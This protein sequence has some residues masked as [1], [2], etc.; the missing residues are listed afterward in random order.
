MAKSFEEQNLLDLFFKEIKKGEECDDSILIEYVESFDNEDINKKKLFRIYESEITPLGLAI[1]LKKE[2]LIDA[3]LANTNTDPNVKFIHPEL[4][5]YDDD[6]ISFNSEYYT[7][8]LLYSIDLNQP[9]TVEKLIKHEKI[10][11][12][13][14]GKNN[15]PF[16]HPLKDAYNERKADICIILL[17]SPLVN[18][19]ENLGMPL[20]TKEDMI[21]YIENNKACFN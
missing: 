11:L 18:D 19:I 10:L 21:K 13:P 2:N 7:T 20:K 16:I 9:K 15:I 8:P 12:T 17:K 3:L 6:D 14:L 5:I 1:Q 4:D